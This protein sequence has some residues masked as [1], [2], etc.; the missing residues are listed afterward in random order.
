MERFGL[1]LFKEGATY[2]VK[3]EVGPEMAAVLEAARVVAG[4][5][6]ATVRQ[7]SEQVAWVDATSAET[8]MVMA[9]TTDGQRCGRH[10]LHLSAHAAYR[11][12]SVCCVQQRV[13]Q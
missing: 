8:Q 6:L 4:E 7:V 3:R 5:Q 1:I 12:L 2:H 9:T 10:Y 13:L 11:K